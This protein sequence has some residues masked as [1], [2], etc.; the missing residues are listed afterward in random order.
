[1]ALKPVLKLKVDELFL[2]WLSEPDTQS[3]LRANLK[4][5]VR[6]EPVSGATRPS[7]PQSPRQ[8]PASP[9]SATPPCSPMTASPR[10][11]RR[12]I[13]NKASIKQLSYK[14]V[15]ECVYECVHAGHVNVFLPS[16]TELWQGNIFTSVCQEFCP[17]RGVGL[18][19]CWDTLP[20]T[21]TPPPPTDG[22]CSGRYA[23]YWNA[24]LY[25]KD[26]LCDSC[27]NPTDV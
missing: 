1:M 11:P 27:H 5:I 3:V 4:Q 6:G 16:A 9:S 23:S 25:W 18:G 20:R 21:D 24:F 2:R 14:Q 7:W 15:S 8:R 26:F 13:I 19:A 12:P 17:Q 22:Y 10:S